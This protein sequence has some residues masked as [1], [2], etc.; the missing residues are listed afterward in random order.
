L[1]QQIPEL[2]V[3][4]VQPECDDRE[5]SPRMCAPPRRQVPVAHRHEWGNECRRTPSSPRNDQCRYWRSI[6]R[7]ATAR[8]N[9]CEVTCREPVGTPNSGTTSVVHP[10]EPLNIGGV[11]AHSD[12][13]KVDSQCRQTTMRSEARCTC[14]PPLHV[15]RPPCKCN[16][17]YSLRSHLQL[18]IDASARA[19]CRHI[20]ADGSLVALTRYR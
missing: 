7:R 15:A 18:M 20:G 16:K 19:R 6:A 11:H 3:V 17:G 8:C 4:L 14:R 13:C 9:M 12:A 10:A 2:V 5:M 1:D